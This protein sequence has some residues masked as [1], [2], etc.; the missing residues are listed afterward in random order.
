[1]IIVHQDRSKRKIWTPIRL[2]A[3]SEPL[4]VSG[5]LGRDA[6][7]SGTDS[8]PASGTHLHWLEGAGLENL[9]SVKSVALRRGRAVVPK[10]IGRLPGIMGER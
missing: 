6:P 8:S 5:E 4:S 9:G 3:I 1:M 2:V 7:V 10:G